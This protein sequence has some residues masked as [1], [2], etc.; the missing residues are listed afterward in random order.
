MVLTGINWWPLQ[1]VFPLMQIKIL[2]LLFLICCLACKNTKQEQ[3]QEEEFDKLK[4]ATKND[5]GYPYRDKMLKD[6]M[7]NHELHGVEKDSLVHLLGTPERTNNGY[8]Y[9]R[10]DED[11]LGFLTLHTKTLVIRL[12]P[13]ST[14]MWLKIHQ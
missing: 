12:T 13:D 7:R 14:V 11:H 2:L 1:K 10:I 8:L 6:L 4:W 9:Y 3:Q 5:A